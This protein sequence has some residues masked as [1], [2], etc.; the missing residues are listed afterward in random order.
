MRKPILAAAAAA[1][2]LAAFGATP[3]NAAGVTGS[4]Q[5]VTV[6]VTQSHSVSVD[7]STCDSLDVTG[8]IQRGGG[9]QAL[10]GGC[11]DMVLTVSSLAL[12]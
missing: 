9:D 7:S 1:S 8:N 10:T 3:A 5:T 11:Q 4:D 2:L 12:S 6:T